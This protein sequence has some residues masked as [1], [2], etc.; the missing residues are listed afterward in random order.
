M[1]NRIYSSRHRQADA[2]NRCAQRR[3][4]AGY[5]LSPKQQLDHTPQPV[6]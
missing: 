2:C 3:A 6:Y 1:A 4:R 5:A